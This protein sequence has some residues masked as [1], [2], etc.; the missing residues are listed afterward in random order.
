MNEFATVLPLLPFQLQM[1]ELD[2][3]PLELLPLA[4]DP[5][6]FRL[7]LIDAL[8]LGGQLFALPLQ[9]LLFFPLPGPDLPP[10]A[11]LFAQLPFAFAQTVALPFFA[12]LL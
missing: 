5:Q 7:L 1:F 12:D 9:P 3:L 8:A 2:L 10:T 6:Q 4:H 11:F